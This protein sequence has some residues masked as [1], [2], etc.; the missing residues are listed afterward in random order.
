[1]AGWRALLKV[2]WVSHSGRGAGMSNPLDVQRTLDHCMQHIKGASEAMA[3]NMHDAAMRL[4]AAAMMLASASYAVHKRAAELTG[5]T[6]GAEA[7]G[8]GGESKPQPPPGT[9]CA[10]ARIPLCV[11]VGRAHPPAARA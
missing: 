2:N 7:G 4:G 6:T 3:E 1:M 5:E 8:R 11:S 10:P 9:A